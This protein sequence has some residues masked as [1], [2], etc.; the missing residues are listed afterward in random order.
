M[1]T[2]TNLIFMNLTKIHDTDK[3]YDQNSRHPQTLTLPQKNMLV[4][5]AW[6]G[7]PSPA[8]SLASL[9]YMKKNI[10]HGY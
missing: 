8:P 7:S 3:H 4:Q 10:W 2:M 9:L 1:F 6:T 5:S